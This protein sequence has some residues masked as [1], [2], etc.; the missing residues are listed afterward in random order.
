M[1]WRADRLSGMILHVLVNVYPPP[2]LYSIKK[3]AWI[4]EPRGGD[5][6]GPKLVSAMEGLRK[7]PRKRFE[8]STKLLTKQLRVVVTLYTCIR[9][10][11]RFEFRL[12]CGLS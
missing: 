9:E 10:V 6:C 4:S 11:T 7:T 1:Q 12:S 8:V 5:I 2:L 3:E